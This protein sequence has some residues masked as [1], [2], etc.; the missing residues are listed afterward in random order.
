[1]RNLHFHLAPG[2]PQQTSSLHPEWPRV[3]ASCDVF[4]RVASMR[5]SACG[6]LGCGTGA[7]GRSEE[8]A[9]A[10]KPA[11]DA[12][13]LGLTGAKNACCIGLAKF[14]GFPKRILHFCSIA[15]VSQKWRIR[16]GNP[17]IS[18]TLMQHAFLD[19]VQPRLAALCSVLLRV[20]SRRG[21]P[22]GAVNSDAERIPNRTETEHM[23][24]R[25]EPRRFQRWAALRCAALARCLALRCVALRFAA[26][27]CVMRV[28][29]LRCVTPR[30][31]AL[32]MPMHS[33]AH[34][35][36]RLFT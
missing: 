20:A 1:M 22:L 10:N 31:A 30:C 5:G 3:A 12:A 23:Q 33:H 21:S 26:L 16:L 11:H 34:A 27:R 4:G 29:A 19:P 36:I 9:N 8:R 15:P 13:N 32:C 17:P 24:N 7:R 35:R 18:A 2:R 6:S 28:A 14:G 25:T